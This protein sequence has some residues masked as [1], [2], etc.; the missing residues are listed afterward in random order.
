MSKFAHYFRCLNLLTIVSVGIYSLFLMFKFGHYF[1]F[2]NVLTI[3]S[4]KICSLFEINIYPKQIAVFWKL[5]C[6]NC[7]HATF[8]YG[9]ETLVIQK[10]M[11]KNNLNI[12]NVV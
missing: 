8:L 1:Q 3:F 2:Q 7:V 5:D 11:E 9:M 6:C 4:D 10:K 12:W